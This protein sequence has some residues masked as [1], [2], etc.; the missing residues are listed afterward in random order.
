M[1]NGDTEE[2][3]VNRKHYITLVCKHAHT[4]AHTHA[5]NSCYFTITKSLIIT[6]SRPATTCN[7]ATAADITATFLHSSIPHVSR[8]Q[9][10]YP[11]THQD[12]FNKQHGHRG[13]GNNNNGGGASGSLAGKVGAKVKKI[14]PACFASSLIGF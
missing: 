12:D 8:N 7:S 9:R 1:Q 2:S 6:F 14:T 11:P 10:R 4:H 3:H 13:H 5:C